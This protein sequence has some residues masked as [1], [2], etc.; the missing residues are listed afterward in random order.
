MSIIM[1]TNESIYPKMDAKAKKIWVR[2]L[3]SG[4]YKQSKSYLCI[5][6]QPGSG[7]S[8]C[9]LGVLC[10]ELG[11]GHWTFVGKSFLQETPHWRYSHGSQ[12]TKHDAMPPE[13]FMK[14]IGLYIGAAE[15][16]AQ[17]NDEGASFDEIADYIKASL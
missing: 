4:D 7:P 1:T 8:F 15:D 14:S 2:A 5:E 11:D 17:L 12:K 13:E 3:R 16:L 6:S 10:E 9:C